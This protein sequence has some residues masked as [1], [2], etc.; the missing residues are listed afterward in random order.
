MWTKH[1][2]RKRVFHAINYGSWKFAWFRV[3][4]SSIHSNC[5]HKSRSNDTVYSFSD[6]IQYFNVMSSGLISWDQTHIVINL[7]FR[8]S[9][10]ALQKIFHNTGDFYSQVRTSAWLWFL[11]FASK[12][13]NPKTL[14]LFFRILRQ[15]LDWYAILM[16][17]LVFL[18]HAFALL[19]RTLSILPRGWIPNS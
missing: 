14:E 5:L 8:S 7:D 10:D 15:D 16:L 12:N 11:E 3:S 19:I 1:L 18:D 9:C 2:V 4:K 17:F 6:V 13:W